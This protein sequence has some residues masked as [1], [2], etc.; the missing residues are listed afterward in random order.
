M[1]TFNSEIAMLTPDHH[2]AS[3]EEKKE[4]AKKLLSIN[5]EFV[6][7]QMALSDAL[8]TDIQFTQNPRDEFYLTDLAI[9]IMTGA[10][11]EDDLK[12][13]LEEV[14][15]C[16][17]FSLYHKT[18]VKDQS[19]VFQGLAHDLVELMAKLPAICNQNWNDGGKKVFLEELLK[20]FPDGG[21][22][23]IQKQFAVKNNQQV[24]A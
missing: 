9:E 13:Y 21:C 6:G 18:L 1:R 19:E 3:I 10:K 22:E 24:L 8:E 7:K 4:K 17:F 15:C 11:E 20:V 12:V 5:F 2:L 14:S 16:T 23:F